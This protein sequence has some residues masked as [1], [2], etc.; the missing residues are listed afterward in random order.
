MIENCNPLGINEFHQDNY[1]EGMD[2]VLVARDVGGHHYRIEN[3]SR[4][5]L[6]KLRLIEDQNNRKCDYLV[7]NCS[8]R[9]AY[10]VELKGQNLSDAVRQIEA[11][12]NALGKRLST[13]KFYCRI[14]QTKVIGAT[15]QADR[16]RLVKYLKDKHKANIEGKVA[17]LVKVGSQVLIDKI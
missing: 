9:N 10:F 8:T 13:F 6:I 17:E 7:L 5:Y 4:N 2:R 16:E 11:T 3:E 12:L 14:V 15:Q 1:Q